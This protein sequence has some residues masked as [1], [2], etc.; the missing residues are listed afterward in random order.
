MII[1]MDQN[2]HPKANTRIVRQ[3][4]RLATF[5]LIALLVGAVLTRVSAGANSGAGPAGFGRGMVQGALMPMAF[6]NL[7]VG[8]DV[9]IYAQN[10]TGIN[11]KLGYTAGVNL[12]GAVFFGFLF[13]RIQRLGTRLKNS[14][15]PQAPPGPAEVR[16]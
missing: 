14:S 8:R 7:L 6:P 10:N 11:Y 5:I 3:A 2:Q 13:L 4:I 1:C 9:P 15:D 12:C 16:N